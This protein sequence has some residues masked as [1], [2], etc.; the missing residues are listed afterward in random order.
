LIYGFSAFCGSLGV[1]LLSLPPA[2][3]WTIGVVTILAVRHMLL[4]LD[5]VEFAPREIRQRRLAL[6]YEDVL[7]SPASL[8]P[9]VSES[10][11]SMA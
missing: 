7:G 11:D 10:R 3:S 5:Y 4:E 6:E 1:L 8:I 2:M 9:R